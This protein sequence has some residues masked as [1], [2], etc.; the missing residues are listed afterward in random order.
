MLDPFCGSATTG[1]AALRHNR[2]FIG[3][4]SEKEYLDKYSIPRLK[5]EFF[6]KNS[7]LFKEG[8]RYVSEKKSEYEL[9]P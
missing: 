2:K 1:V 6:R 4:D 3:V 7:S 9:L 8:Y 5:D